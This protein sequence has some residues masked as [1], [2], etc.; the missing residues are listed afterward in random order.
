MRLA[1]TLTQFLQDIR[2]QKMRTTLTIMGITW[3]TVAVIV[4]LAFGVGLEKQSRK[5]MHGMGDGIVVMFGGRTTKPFQGFPDGR[6]IRLEEADVPVLVSEIPDIGQISPEYVNRSTS[7]RRDRSV[8]T[9]AITG[10]YP[11]YADMR[12]IIAEPGGRFINELDMKQRRRVVLLGNEIKRLLFGDDSTAV[13]QQVMI[14]Q[15]PFVVI[16]I[17]EPK[18]QNSSYNSRDSDRIF[19]PASTFRSMFGDRYINNIVYRPRA[20][21]LVDAI[22]S[23]VY[24]VMGQ[25]NR[26]DPSDE[27]AIGL[28][29]TNEAD[30]FMKAFFLG[31][32]IFMAIIGSF[33]LT[34]GGIGVANIMYVVVRERTKEI[35]VKRSV[36]A[37]KRDIL[38]QF[39]FE[40]FMIVSIGASLGFVIALGLIKALS[41]MPIQ[42]FVGTPQLS[43]VVAM[44]TMALLAFIAF[45]AGFFPARKAAALDPVECLRT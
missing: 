23:R 10:I 31:F 20:P 32:N 6:S 19:I 3:G 1:S 4:L 5:N 37:R 34:V 33:T 35:G 2:A 44:T 17:M 26:F 8:T 7:V 30:K 15:T 11:V 38:R 18:T 13:G 28:W 16:G 24:Q 45:L 22:E 36:G 43:P 12:N 9:P 39:F 14:G 25:R 42:D 40:T 41:Y 21:E 29:D 27:D